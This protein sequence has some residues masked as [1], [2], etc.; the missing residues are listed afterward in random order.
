MKSSRRGI[1]GGKET[2]DKSERVRAPVRR[3]LHTRDAQPHV[4]IGVAP[5][6]L[7]TITYYSLR[8]IKAH[9]MI[10]HKRDN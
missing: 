7:F 2:R 10:C 6:L 8:A 5:L 4:E 9:F 1:L 3:D